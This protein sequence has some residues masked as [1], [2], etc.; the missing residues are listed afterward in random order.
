MFIYYNAN[1]L[2]NNSNMKLKFRIHFWMKIEHLKPRTKKHY[3]LKMQFSSLGAKGT[4]FVWQSQG[5]K[6]DS[7][8]KYTFDCE[9]WNMYLFWGY[10]YYTMVFFR[11]TIS[12]LWIYIIWCYEE[13]GH[14]VLFL[15]SWN[16]VYK[17]YRNKFEVVF[18]Q[19]N[20]L[21]CASW[22]FGYNL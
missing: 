1:E 8:P 7:A 16:N 12:S 4:L 2:V 22:L 14:L 6:F 10:H 21:Q 20:V 19:N 9:W 15:V 17:L 18:A 13:C 5:R 3:W 11:N